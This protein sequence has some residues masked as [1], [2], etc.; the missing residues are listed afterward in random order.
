VS[1]GHAKKIEYCQTSMRVR[2]RKA[3]RKRSDLLPLTKVEICSLRLQWTKARGKICTAY[4]LSL[5]ISL[6]WN[7]MVI[8][9]SRGGTELVQ[10]NP[11]NP[12]QEAV[13]HA[14]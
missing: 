1:R 3:D 13:E 4:H 5:F 9:K 2:A 10:K 12:Y 14:G 6:F 7:W 8:F 11:R